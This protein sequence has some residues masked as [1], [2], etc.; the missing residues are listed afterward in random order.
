M[1]TTV[2]ELCESLASAFSTGRLDDVLG[3]YIH[4]LAIYMPDGFRVEMTPEETME[5]IFVRRALALRAG[6]QT[7][8]VTIDRVDTI[9]G[10]RIL[11][12]LSWDFLGAGGDRV[13]RSV[14]RYFCRRA[15]DARLRVEMIE[16]MEKAF[17]A[18]E[19]TAR[20]GPRH[21]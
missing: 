20:A 19:R 21:H 4:P 11:V 13:G 12:H 8:R 9:E 5:V 14:M 1:A 17:E 10:G 2:E 7:V 6:M 18:A 16:F 15:P 3:H